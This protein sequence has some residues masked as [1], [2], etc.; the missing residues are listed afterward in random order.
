MA[1]RFPLTYGIH[2][3]QMNDNQRALMEAMQMKALQTDIISGIIDRSNISG[4]KLAEIGRA[5]LG[6]RPGD[7]EWEDT[8]HSGQYTDIAWLDQRVDEVCKKGRL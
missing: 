4:K 6:M 3:Q 2:T 5:V 7:P 8:K 1:I